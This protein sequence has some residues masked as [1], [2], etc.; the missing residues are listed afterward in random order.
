MSGTHRADTAALG[1]ATSDTFL[2]SDVG[3]GVRWYANR[4]RGVRGDYRFLVVQQKDQAAPF[5]G[6][7]MRYEHR[8]YAAVVVKLLQ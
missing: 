6:R 4:R 2:M 3:G 8:V 5:F 1:I 7:D